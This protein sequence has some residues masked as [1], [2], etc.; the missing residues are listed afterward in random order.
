MFRLITEH[1]EKVFSNEVVMHTKKDVDP[2]PRGVGVYEL[3]SQCGLPGIP[4]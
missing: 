4:M 1:G 2:A 3:R